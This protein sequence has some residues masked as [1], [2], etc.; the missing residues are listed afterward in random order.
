MQLTEEKKNAILDFVSKLPLSEWR[1][2]G[3]NGD[4]G[5]IANVSEKWRVHL[6]GDKIRVLSDIATNWDIEFEAYRIIKYYTDIDALFKT[7][8]IDEEKE[9][10]NNFLNSIGLSDAAN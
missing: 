4:C 3:P 1:G 6:T 9:Y 10:F 8:R 2:Y 5:F 7:K